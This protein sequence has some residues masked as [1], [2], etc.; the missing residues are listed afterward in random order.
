M[1]KQSNIFRWIIFF[2]IV[3]FAVKALI[4]TYKVYFSAEKDE[5]T[6]IK[7]KEEVSLISKKQKEG[8]KLTV[9]EENLLKSY[10]DNFELTEDEIKKLDQYNNSKSKSLSLGLDLQGGMYLALEIDYNEMLKKLA[11]VKDSN[12]E[13]LLSQAIKKTGN[14]KETYFDNVKAVFNENKVLLNKYFGKRGDSDEKVLALLDST[15][16]KGI[17][18]TLEVLRNRIDE[19]GI[20]EPTIQKQGDHRVVVELPGVKD[21]ERAK[22]LV[23]RAAFLE[24]KIVAQKEDYK[25]IADKLDLIVRKKKGLD[26][27]QENKTEADTTS[28][29]ENIEDS[30]TATE[31]ATGL[32]DNN[33]DIAKEESETELNVNKPFTSLLVE[34]PSRL[35]LAVRAKDKLMIDEILRY[36]ETRKALGEFEF[37][38]KNK[39][40]ENATGEKF[41]E[42]FLVYK[43]A[44]LDGTSINEATANL[45]QSATSVGGWEV[46]LSFDPIGTRRF[47]EATGKNVNKRLAIILDGKLYM[48]PNI[49]VRIPDGRARITG[50][51]QNEAR[52]MAVVLKAGAL[53][54]PLEIM[55][56][57]VVGPSLGKDSIESGV[58]AA[59][60]GII[61]VMFFMVI[62]YKLNGLFSVVALF[63]NLVFLTAVLSFFKATLTLPGIAGIILTIGMAVDANVLIFERIKEE[64]RDKKTVF[65]AVQAGYEKAFSAIFDANITTLIAAIALYQFGTGPIKGFALTLMIGIVSSMYTALVVTKLLT[66]IF[67][68][69]NTKKL[70]IA[71][72]GLEKKEKKFDFI[73]KRKMAAVTSGIVIAVS[74]IFILIQG[75]LNY[76][77][78]FNGGYQVQAAFKNS[79]PINELRN[80]FSD[81]EIKGVQLQELSVTPGDEETYKSEVMIKVETMSEDVADIE[82]KVISLLD[83][84]SGVGNYKISQASSIGPKIGGELKDAAVNAILLSLLGIL[85]YITIRF[86]FRYG[87]AAI[88]A[89]FHDVLITVGVFSII[90]L[91]LD[92]E[93]SLAVIAAIL[94]IVGYSLNDTI[95]VFDRIRENIDKMENM[96]FATLVNKSINGTISRTLLTSITTLFVVLILFIFGGE[97]IRDLSTTLLIGVVV[98]TYSSIFVA[99]PVL[100]WWNER[101]NKKLKKS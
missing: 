93:V 9:A 10:N 100:I 46:G 6:K 62:Y 16:K 34:S 55:E 88:I 44:E 27:A 83:T 86:L 64:L 84:K 101:K 65:S 43:K 18:T 87:I 13:N 49:Q 73:G 48:A 32:S 54:A 72:S 23:N 91:I 99:S 7:A 47:A 42:L 60:A 58:K 3:G 29:V 37:V 56:K 59:L 74:I 79:T 22:N 78:E 12:L 61:V 53:P 39:S 38:W 35:E 1:K 71:F 25:R 4:P 2:V 5:I 68:N 11:K 82:T 92:L 30:L 97:V 63:L 26:K 77:I 85:I 20:A 66:D 76:N 57:R 95:V 8:K 51:D 45:D 50:V 96:D 28:S 89:L 15:S 98:G 21:V 14:K 40:V 33:L 69:K 75:G 94:T 90:G 41:Y 17:I 19:F 52:D 24:F 36:D 81:S 80:W 31:D 67:V 70:A